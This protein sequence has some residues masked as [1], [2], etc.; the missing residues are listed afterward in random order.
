MTLRFVLSLLHSGRYFFSFFSGKNTI[1][2]PITPSAANTCCQLML[3]SKKYLHPSPK[4]PSIN[5]M[6][7]RI[8]VIPLNWFF[9]C[10]SYSSLDQNNVIWLVSAIPAKAPSALS[11][12]M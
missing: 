1:A 4:A 2:A 8:R 10:P 9:I 6:L 12:S 3:K 5:V 7:S 11:C